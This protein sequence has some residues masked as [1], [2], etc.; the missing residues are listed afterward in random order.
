M[1][2]STPALT[3]A[4]DH[5]TAVL[6]HFATV[7]GAA[8]FVMASEESE[9]LLLFGPAAAPIDGFANV[10]L[11]RVVKRGDY[12]GAWVPQLR[13]EMRPHLPGEARHEPG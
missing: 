1:S 9:L 3:D 10:R 6:G 4:S 5:E 8:L 12:E 2:Q 13:A 7:E 11:A